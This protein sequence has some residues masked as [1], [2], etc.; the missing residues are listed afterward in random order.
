MSPSFTKHF[1][2]HTHRVEAREHFSLFLEIFRLT[3]EIFVFFVLRSSN[4]RSRWF[5]TVPGS[6]RARREIWGLYA[7]ELD[8]FKD[9]EN[10]EEALACLNHM[11]TDA[12]GHATE[13]LDYMSE[14]KHKWVFR[15]C[16]IPQ[17]MA[18]GKT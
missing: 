17:V 11:I 3:S 8:E 9:P 18:I 12:L 14:L 1:G 2:K 10:R 6:W 16:A 5:F 13:S 15:F 7:E 4:R